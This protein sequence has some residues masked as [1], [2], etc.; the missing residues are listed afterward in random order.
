MSGGARP[1]AAQQIVQSL[2]R[3]AR[4][5]PLGPPFADALS[6]YHRFPRP[7][8]AAAAAAPAPLDG[9]R[10]GIEEGIV[11]RAPVIRLSPVLPPFA[12]APGDY[13]RFRR[14]SSPAAAA[15]PLAGGG[16]DI[17]EGI[18]VRTP[19]SR[20]LERAE[21]LCYRCACCF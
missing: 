8:A 9:G 19:V 2:Q 16:G 6:D 10:G 13:H 20:R 18:V 3:C 17:E 7:S 1:A 12:S 21:E 5:P 15:A 11:L 4:L 14:P